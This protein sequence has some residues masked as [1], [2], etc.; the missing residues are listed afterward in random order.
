LLGLFFDPENG[1]TFFSEMSVDFQWTTWYYI[2]EDGILHK[3]C[4]ENLVSHI[5]ILLTEMKG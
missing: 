5:D 2:P 4:C 1:G 3:H